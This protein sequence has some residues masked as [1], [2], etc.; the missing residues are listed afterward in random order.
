M[1]PVHEKQRRE[2]ELS[3]YLDGSLD[4]DA[5]RRVEARLADDAQLAEDLRRYRALEGHL[6][7]MGDETPRRIPPELQ[8]AEIMAAIERRMLLGGRRR[9]SW[10]GVAGGLAAA[11]AV[12]IAA[13]V[14]VWLF[15]GREPGDGPT[16]SVANV[17]LAPVS[18]TAGGEVQVSVSRPQ[19][20]LMPLAAP[21]EVRQGAWPAGMVLVSVGDE[22]PRARTPVP[23]PVAMEPE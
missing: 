19:F 2:F 12:L 17:S 9:R 13:A 18:R 21:S 1:K 6:A 4:A 5:R 16:R 8:R 15:S 7:E 10:R 14:G 3:E 23:T 11:A 22:P 20:E